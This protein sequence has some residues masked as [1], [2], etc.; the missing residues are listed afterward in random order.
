MQNQ[1]SSDQK[2]IRAYIEG[3]EDCIRLLI[4][5]HKEK[6]FSY[7][8]FLIKDKA[9]ADDVFQDTFI[10]VVNTLKK[11]TYNEEGKFIVWVKRIA[12]NLVIDHFRKNKRMPLVHGND[13]YDVFASIGLEEESIEERMLTNQTHAELRELIEFLPEEQKS[14]LKAEA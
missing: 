3:D 13:D 14:V 1:I 11:G 9:L 8:Y 2:L 5:R 12:H 4:N 7:I 10:K 6:V